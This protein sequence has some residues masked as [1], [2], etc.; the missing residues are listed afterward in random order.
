MSNPMTRVAYE[1]Y[2]KRCKE[3]RI[4]PTSYFELTGC[5]HFLDDGTYVCTT[6]NQ[7]KILSEFYK[8]NTSKGHMSVCKECKKI[9]SSERQKEKQEEKR[10]LRKKQQIQATKNNQKKKKEIIVAKENNVVEKT[11]KDIVPGITIENKTYTLT[12]DELLEFG[13]AAFERGRNSV[14]KLTSD[15]KESLLDEIC[16]KKVS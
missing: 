4:K 3:N 9:D 16:S 10:E 13:K 2:K 12:K 1:S 7:E 5:R 14:N 8:D 6:C 11:K 15:D